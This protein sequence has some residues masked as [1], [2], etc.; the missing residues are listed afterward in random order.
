MADHACQ[1]GDVSIVLLGVASGVYFRHMLE[2]LDPNYARKV[3]HHLCGFLE[4]SGLR[5]VVVP[6]IEFHAR[7]LLEKAEISFGDQVM[8]VFA[9][10]WGWRDEQRGV[11]DKLRIVGD[12]ANTL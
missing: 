3:L 7:Q 11:V 10:F 9:G 1:T 4:S 5:H 12:T 8:H 2:H 6:D